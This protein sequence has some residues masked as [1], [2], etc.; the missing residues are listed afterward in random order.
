MLFTLFNLLH[1][2]QGQCLQ[3]VKR[4]FSTARAL[5]GQQVNIYFFYSKNSVLLISYFTVSRLWYVQL[6]RKRVHIYT[7]FNYLLIS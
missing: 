4:S 2:L 6:R 7:K 3:H 5:A 1:M